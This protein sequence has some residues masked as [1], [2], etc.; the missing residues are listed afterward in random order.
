MGGRILIEVKNLSKNYGKIKAIKNLNFTVDNGEIL[1]LLGPNG[2][3]KS[4]TMKIITGFINPTEGTVIVDGFD[5]AEENMEAKKKIG[6]LPENPPLYN[7][8][9]VNSYLKFVGEIKGISKNNIQAR[10]NEVMEMLNITEVSGRLIKNLSKGYKQRV[11][12]AQAI[13]GD[14][15]VLI[16]DEP[17]SGL[18]PN[19]IIE[20]RDLIRKLGK[21][22]TIILSTHILPEVSQLCERVIIINNGE[23]VAIDTPDNLSD[24][25]REK[26]LIE[27]RIIGLQPQVVNIIKSINGVLKVDVLGEKERG[28]VDYKIESEK[29]IDIRSELFKVI[30]ENNFQIIELKS[31]N[32]SLEDIFLHLTTIEEK[33]S[34]QDIK[35]GNEEVAQDEKN[36]SNI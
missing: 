25:F 9:V 1:G 24:K 22:R 28:A 16:L 8:M 10:V 7:D 36:D 4:T 6:Y 12:L 11:G 19:Q 35:Q 26:N 17:T 3:G 15:D 13:L 5:I 21:D 34:V 2:A 29:D 14:P 33:E 31:V 18:D 27:A 20:I 32:L 30:T 23:I